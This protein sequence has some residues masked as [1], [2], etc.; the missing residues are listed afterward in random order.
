M[1]W[2]EVRCLWNDREKRKDSNHFLG[3]IAWFLKIKYKT[4]ISAQFGKRE[5]CFLWFN[6]VMKEIQEWGG[7][8]KVRVKLS[9]EPLPTSF[10]S[11][12]SVCQDA[13]L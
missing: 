10:G 3:C 11:K 8:E 7:Q 2:K 4:S 12:Y 9:F 1:E 6:L 5:F 13:V